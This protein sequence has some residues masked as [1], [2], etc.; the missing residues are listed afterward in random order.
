MSVWHE[1]IDTGSNNDPVISSSLNADFSSYL[2]FFKVKVF[3]LSESYNHTSR[4]WAQEG[5]SMALL[6]FIHVT[7][8]RPHSYNKYLSICHAPG[9]MVGTGDQ[10]VIFSYFTEGKKVQWSTG[11][12]FSLNQ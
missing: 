9:T 1:I 12:L 6:L 3:A 8:S 10:Q 4:F 7:P 5:I 2:S 11:S